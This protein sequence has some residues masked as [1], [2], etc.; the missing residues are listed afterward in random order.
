MLPIEKE[1]HKACPDCEAGGRGYQELLRVPP[2]AFETLVGLRR[3]HSARREVCRVRSATLAGLP[4]CEEGMPSCLK[5]V[6]EYYDV[7]PLVDLESDMTSGA[8]YSSF[9]LPGLPGWKEGDAMGLN[10]TLK[11]MEPSL[12]RSG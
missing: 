6:H 10:S 1:G 5:M 9:I 3:N 7:K 12:G 2:H 8:R 11:R 4:G